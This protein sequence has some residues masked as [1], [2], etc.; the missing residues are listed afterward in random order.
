MDPA[1][2][3][4]VYLIRPYAENP[5]QFE[6]VCGGLPFKTRI[7]ASYGINPWLPL[8]EPLTQRVS[9]A[10]E[11]YAGWLQHDCAVL[12][13]VDLESATER[14][15]QNIRSAL[16]RGLPLLLC[17]GGFG[18]GSSYRLWHD[19]EEALP[20]GI[21][22]AAPVDCKRRVTTAESHPIVRGLPREFGVVNSLHAVEVH[23]DAQVLLQAGN[24]PVLVTS[25][26]FGGRQLLLAVAQADGLCCDSL[27]TE[28]FYGHPFYP[29]LMRRCLT[30]LMDVETPLW[31]ESLEVELASEATIRAGVRQQTA[32]PGAT[33]RC[34]VSA[35][36]EA[37]LAS[38]GDTR[39]SRKLREEARP[40]AALEQDETFSVEDMLA[41]KCSGVYEVEL[42]LEMEEP[43]PSVSKQCFGMGAPPHWSNWKGKAVDVRR[44]HVRFPDRRRARAV[45][46]GRTFTLEESRPWRVEASAADLV[47]SHLVIRDFDGDPVGDVAD[48]VPGAQQLLW[49][50]PALV[51]GD[52]TATLT[53]L[54]AGNVSEE[55]QFALKAVALPCADD[56]FHLVSHRGRAN[57]S[58]AEILD[59]IRANADQFGLDTLSLPGLQIAEKV[60]DESVVWAQQPYAQRRL[61]W[62]D[63]LAAAEGRHLWNDFDSRLVVLATH[64]VGKT[65]APT[66]PCVHDPGYEESARALLEPMLR[67]QAERTGLISTE[68]IDEPHLLPS[69]VCR[70][71]RCQEL[72]RGRFGE[73]MPEHEAWEGDQGPRRWHLFEWLEDYT[74]R[75]FATTRKIKDEIA[76]GLHLH[77]VA[78]D[79]LFSSNFMFNGMHRWAAFGDELYMA[80][81]P[82]SYRTW[83]GHRQ[84]PHSQTH[85]IA[86]WIRGLARHYGIPWGVFME[87]WEHDAPNRW[88]PEYWSVC[89][90]YSLLA[91]GADRLDTFYI[92]FG[93]EVF[94]ISFERLHE[95]GREVNS[96]RP[97][98]PLL[99]R[100]ARP[101]ARMAFVNPWAEW[102]M[103]PQP[104]Y[105]PPGHE[106]YGYYRRY[107]IPLDKLYP[108]ENRRMLAYELFHRTFNDLDQVDEQLLCE[109]PLDYQA[110]VVC[111]CT[112]LMRNTM[113][114]LR[115]FVEA[116]GVLVLDCMPQRDENGSSADFYDSITRGEVLHAGVI[117]PGLQHQVF[118]LGKGKVLHFSASLQTTYADVV[119]SERTGVRARLEGAV[120]EL[121][122]ELGLRSR[123][124]SSNGDID[125][126]LRRTDD[127]CLVPV[128]NTSPHRQTARVSLRELPFQPVFAANLTDGA[129]FDVQ[130][131]DGAAGLEVA[132]DGYH[133][134]LYA[135]YP[136]KP[137][138][139]GLSMASRELKRGEELTY[140]VVLL[141]EED[142]AAH[143]AFVVKAAVTD[144]DGR[145]HARLGGPLVVRKGRLRFQKRLPVNAR[146]GT[147][148]V[149][150][151]EPI[152]GLA[153]EAEF[154]VIGE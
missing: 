91:E 137:R 2:I 19:V 105:L 56:S 143:G 34:S 3:R 129:F 135:L 71:E 60:W 119:E 149:R 84:M 57:A 48:D 73:E 148:H 51:E 61:R 97:F 106:G 69:N 20:C 72:Y 47:S 77:N 44:F 98:F 35:V 93:V 89:Q 153:A 80:C 52:Y 27:S 8:S 76:P 7:L 136:S 112:F 118:S 116:G 113:E 21:P 58:D 103:N 122:G 100:A 130:G 26:R 108:S 31:L 99:T 32:N 126:G 65:Y 70:C 150:I 92:S 43:P 12:A 54:R 4:E 144:G 115:A 74:A 38:G 131:S 109:A 68:I 15:V 117:V 46:P 146:P 114:K 67:L 102:V 13:G 14:D 140:E 63:A 79:R 139:L 138:S 66:V 40:I 39:T 82:W 5:Y 154:T 125:A 133:G 30:W 11:G 18:L 53:A 23:E 50:V 152:I 147:W 62:I 45:V 41:G 120:A 36:D 49:Q 16:E 128:A 124:I 9:R 94:G 75:A 85:W 42:S 141:S 142:T 86:A 28:G 127:L 90:F 81:Y 6:W 55:F 78:I 107:A 29:D 22:A 95:F 37:R 33:L 10:S 145:E 24:A 83:R 111:D 87:L 123:C 104:H 59:L 132:L 96:I 17:G 101:R 25:E 88:L 64:G 1:G 121:L 151:S 134:A 110:I